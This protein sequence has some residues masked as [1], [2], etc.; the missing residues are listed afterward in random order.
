MRKIKLELESLSV[1]TFETAGARA[2]IR[3]TVRGESVI[4]PAPLSEAPFECLETEI[5]G[6]CCEYTLVLSC[7]QTGCEECFW[8]PVP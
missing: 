1:E 5:T 7:V 3:G 6:P 4:E 2:E 8:Q